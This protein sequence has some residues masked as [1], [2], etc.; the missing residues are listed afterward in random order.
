MQL[1]TFDHC[2]I[3]CFYQQYTLHLLLSSLNICV[4]CLR[5]SFLFLV[6]CS[7]SCHS[8]TFNL[9]LSILQRMQLVI[10]ER[11]WYKVP[12]PSAWIQGPFFA[13]SNSHLVLVPAL[14]PLRFRPLS[15]GVHC[16]SSEYHARTALL[17]LAT[18]PWIWYSR[19]GQT[20]A[21]K[22]P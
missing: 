21:K 8:S 9:A 14:E 4:T 1:Y 18:F 12:L 19:F 13:P 2:L 6:C 3:A 10:T 5:L 22:H 20:E 16:C 15:T 11:S 17:L 7:S